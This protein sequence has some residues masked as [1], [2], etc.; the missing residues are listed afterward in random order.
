MRRR[1]WLGVIFQIERVVVFS[2]TVLFSLLL[3]NVMLTLVIGVA[4]DRH[5]AWPL[6]R[7][8]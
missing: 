2:L 8:R 1:L 3:L 7:E 6:W 4:L 5:R